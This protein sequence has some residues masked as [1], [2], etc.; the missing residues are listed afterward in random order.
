M[1][2]TLKQWQEKIDARVIRER[3]LIF[4]TVLAVI[5][6]LWN[7]TLQ[8]SV[9]KKLQGSR[10]QIDA[11]TTQR[12]TLQ[13]QILSATQALLNNPDTSKKAQIAQLTTDVSNV[14]T[15]LQ[16]A[17]QSL[18]K[19]DQL[20]LAL[21]DVLQKTTQLTLLEVET[22]PVRELQID[23]VGTD[24]LSKGS[25]TKTNSTTGSSSTTAAGVYEHAVALHVSGNYFQVVQFLT[26][27]EQLPWKFYWQSL[28]YKVT[29]YP[30][31]EI[32]LRVYTLSAEEGLL[33]V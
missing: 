21:Q 25:S 10:D 15:Q 29:K 1:L 6:A 18:I 26:A 13:T 17:S 7:F 2:A 5:F 24:N 27:L 19:A 9:E 31:A 3:G 16:S 4:I 8:A 30:N 20:P 32:I 14:E 22:L 23:Q 28:D 12:K 11:A 33:G